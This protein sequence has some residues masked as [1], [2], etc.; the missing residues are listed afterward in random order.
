MARGDADKAKVFSAEEL[1]TVF[2]LP[3]QVALTPTLN[4][5]GSTRSEAPANLPVGNLPT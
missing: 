4:R 1:A 3:G 5:I 2:H